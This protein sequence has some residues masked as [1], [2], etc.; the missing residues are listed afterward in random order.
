[1]KGYKIIEMK[2]ESDFRSVFPVMQELRP[3]LSEQSF[4]ELVQEAVSV[5]RYHLYGLWN[6]GVLVAAAGFKP[7]TTLYYGRFVWVCDLVTTAGERSSGWGSI[8]LQFIEGWAEQHGFTSIAL[9]SGLTRQRAHKFYEKH[10]QYEK[11]ST[12]FRKQLDT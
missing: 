4:V 5:D 11:V 6:D 9:S 7:M 8:L 3:H 2:T 1:M 12:V 10:M